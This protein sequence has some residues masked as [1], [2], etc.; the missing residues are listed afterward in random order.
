MKMFLVR[1][2]NPGIDGANSKSL[3]IPRRRLT[4]TARIFAVPAS[5]FGTVEFFDDKPNL[6]EDQGLVTWLS[7]TVSR[8]TTL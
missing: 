5:G 4:L 3:S 1:L 6:P 2:L 8:C 7:C